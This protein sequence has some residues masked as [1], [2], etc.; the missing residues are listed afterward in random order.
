MWAS[1]VDAGNRPCGEVDPDG[2]SGGDGSM[3]SRSG[4]AADDGRFSSESTVSAGLSCD[5]E[6]AQVE[7]DRSEGA[8]AVASWR[9]DAALRGRTVATPGR[10]DR[11][12]TADSTPETGILL[13][14]DLPAGPTRRRSGSARNVLALS[15]GGCASML[16]MR[17]AR[18]QMV[19]ASASRLSRLSLCEA[20]GR[21]GLGIGGGRIALG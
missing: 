21:M 8:L 16:W 15:G 9:C 3:G 20:T 12:V 6:G 5:C 14:C 18:R 13:R 17:A 4:G 2:G 7:R 19:V 11:S 10:P 1:A